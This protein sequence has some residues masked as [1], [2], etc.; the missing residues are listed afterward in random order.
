M[1]WHKVLNNGEERDAILAA[2][3]AEAKA[4]ARKRHG[5]RCDII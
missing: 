5:R 1:R 2:S 4:I 3:F